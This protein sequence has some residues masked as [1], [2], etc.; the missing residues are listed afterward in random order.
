M[1]RKALTAALAA[2]ALASI[3]AGTALAQGGPGRMGERGW[4]MWNDD[5]RGWGMWHGGPFAR[6]WGR[7][8]DWMVEHIEGRLSFLKTELKIT[9][10][11]TGAWNELAQAIRATAK[12]R[13]ERMKALSASEAKAKTLPERVELQE[14]FMTAR[15][16]ELRQ[17]KTGLQSLYAVLT[18]DQK[19]EADDMVL[20][21]VGMGPGWGM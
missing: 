7:G 3:I 2:T 17:V 19:K 11:Q 16:E 10:A 14:Q 4:G 15:L 13:S 8:P 20:P 1:R 9:E 18:D 6:W 12:Q 5:D 21:M